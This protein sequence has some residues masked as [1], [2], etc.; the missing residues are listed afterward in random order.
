MKIIKHIN[1]VNIKSIYVPSSVTY[2]IE[3]TT[4]LSQS[5]PAGHQCP[6]RKWN[7]SPDESM[8]NVQTGHCQDLTGVWG[9]RELWKQCQQDKCNDSLL[10]GEPRGKLKRYV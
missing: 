7:V 6:G 2:L 4:I 10:S 5:P 1:V 9:R 3:T 8:R